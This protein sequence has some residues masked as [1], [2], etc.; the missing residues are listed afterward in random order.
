MVFYRLV[1]S[2]FILNMS[3][4]H[5]FLHLKSN[6]KFSLLYSYGWSDQVNTQKKVYLLVLLS[7]IIHKS[8]FHYLF[9]Y[10][11]SKTESINKKCLAKN[12][13]KC[14]SMKNY[15]TRYLFYL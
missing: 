3:H 1:G 11:E 12:A 4:V 2:L 14:I 9:D 6:I 7:F 15:F 5:S 8:N 10:V 13:K